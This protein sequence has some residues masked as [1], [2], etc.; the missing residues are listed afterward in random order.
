MLVAS[1]LSDVRI[2]LR[3]LLRAP[4]FTGVVLL[5]LGVAIGANT[6]IFSV[7]DG[8]LLRPLPYPDADRLV[9]V[10]ANTLPAPGR[11]GTLPFSDRG[12]WH[13]V[14]NNRSFEEF[15]GYAGGSI[16]WAL[17]GEGAPVQVDVSA[18]TVSA[19]EAL[20]TL[21]QRGRLPSPEED[22]PDGPQVTVISDGLWRSVFG[23]DP[24]V[25][26]RSIE[27]NSQ[28]WEIIGIMPPG[29]AFP[30]PEVDVWIPHQLD[31]ASENYGG[32][33]LWAVA[34]LRPDA[35]LESATTDAEDL[36][37]RFSEAGYTPQ[38]FTGVFSGE[39]TVTSV[40]ED[41]IGDARLPLLIVLGTVGFVL[42]IACSN[43]ANLFLVR[44]ETRARETAVRVALGSGRTRLVRFVMTESILL[45][46]AGGLLG[47][48][49]A[50]IGTRALVAAAP[51]VIPRLDEIGVSGRALA[52]T[53]AI[54]LAAGLLFGLVP[55]FSTGR[56]RMLRAL[57]D[58]GRGGIG[59]R[60]QHRLRNV[61]VVGQIA[62]ALML[63]V[64]SGL[65]VR[66][67]QELR[68][69]DPGFQADNVVTFRVS[70][71]PAKYGGIEPIVG[72]Y[73]NLLAEIRGLPGVTAAGATTILPLSGI[74][75]RLTTRIDDFPIA[76]DEFPPSFLIRRVTP[77]YFEAMGVPVTEGRE[78][79]GD[80][81]ESRLG[82]MVI[83][84]AIK[85]QYWP[86]ESALG[87]RLTT[88]GAPARVVGVV[89]DV[90]FLTVDVPA[91]GTIYKPM[92]DSIGGGVVAMSVAVRAE[93]DAAALIP[94]IRGVVEG[95]DPDLP[96]TN[97][98]ML[99]DV[100]GDSMSRTSFTMTLLVIAALVALFLGAVGVYGVTAY[101]VSQRT[102][103]I[104]VRQALGADSGTVAGMVLGEGMKLALVG[105]V[106]GLVGAV[107]LGRVV[108]SLLFGV[109]PYDGVTLV[110]GSAIFLVVAALATTIPSRRAAAI[111]PAVA[112]RT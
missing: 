97:V 73:D 61:L 94:Q 38:W 62:L 63:L 49:L 32:H 45:A 105:V 56:G 79:I 10:A 103:E 102:G 50:W 43:V 47:I 83:S 31:P 39:A 51:P 27:M 66:T 59:G 30:S 52:F 21:P 8:V 1:L 74:G 46:I 88:A 44:A 19:F 33:H 111:P 70:P 41:L 26:G 72:F 4:G 109:S 87:K 108:A 95:L 107:A 48:L 84:Q 28:T 54:S 11:T 85:D 89:G 68:S 29:Y 90:P 99:G 16:Q 100:V 24:D 36:I 14:E 101:T 20:G 40:K 93:R 6:A 25:I 12:Y 9:S 5:T 80:D 53:L 78:F 17:T 34:R 64:G 82:S 86:E 7:V 55:A 92:L 69:I 77:G 57:R 76:P 23:G 104:G 37:S 65:M 67:F 42:L 112:L 106:L 35:T 71:A 15:G 22:I 110:V 75:S 91:T 2:A 98:Q 3:S 60:G 18:M 81:H 58:G 13:F 96:M